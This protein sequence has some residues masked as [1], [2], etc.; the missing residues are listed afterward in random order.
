RRWRRATGPSGEHEAEDP[1]PLPP[2]LSPRTPTRD[3]D[4]GG[5][6]SRAETGGAPGGGHEPDVPES[7]AVPTD[8]GDIE[9][10]SRLM[11]FLRD[12]DTER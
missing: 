3:G 10:V 2:R 8:D 5:R 12:S 6:A 4:G 7:P 11:E 9:A 1:E